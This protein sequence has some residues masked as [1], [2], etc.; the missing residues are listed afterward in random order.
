MH[1][2]LD[3]LIKMKDKIIKIITIILIILIIIGNLS[4]KFSETR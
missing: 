2:Y 4:V 3:V 1:K